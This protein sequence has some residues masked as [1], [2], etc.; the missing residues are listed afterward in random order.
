[1]E[2]LMVLGVS[3]IIGILS[4]FLGVWITR[5]PPSWYS[6]K[7][8]NFCIAVSTG[9]LLSIAFLEF[10]PHTLEQDKGYLLILVGVLVVAI[11]DMFLIPRLSFL[12]FLKSPPSSEPDG[13]ENTSHSCSHG[14]HHIYNHTQGLSPRVSCSATGCLLVCSF[15]D[16]FE[17]SSAFMIDTQTGIILSLALFFHLLPD[18]MLVASLALAGGLTKKT[19][20]YLS[21]GVG[22]S[23]LMGT[24]IGYGLGEFFMLKA[25]ILAFATGALLYICFCHLLP[26]AFRKPYGLVTVTV[27]SLIFSTILILTH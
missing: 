19:A 23:L 1:M 25:S 24:F 3:L 5:R 20:E 6:E 11:T 10:V 18:G 17:I 15:F 7:K 14:P 2:L 21:I 4:S 16:G 26:L 12:N 22:V 27:S 13:A 8:M 9:V